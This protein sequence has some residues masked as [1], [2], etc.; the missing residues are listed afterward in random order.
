M[1]WEGQGA[2]FL[3]QASTAVLLGPWG[4][5]PA[6]KSAL[7]TENWGDSTLSQAS[8]WAPPMG[9]LCPSHS[10]ILGAYLTPL[11]WGGVACCEGSA[12]ESSTNWHTAA[13]SESLTYTVF[14]RK[15]PTS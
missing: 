10:P 6:L 3:L 2:P 15:E 5:L 1:A 8:G 7:V 11:M 9:Y 12:P 4:P 13:A 14:L